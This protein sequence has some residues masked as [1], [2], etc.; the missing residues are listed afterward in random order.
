MRALGNARGNFKSTTL[1]PHLPRRA[2]IEAYGKGGFR[3]AG[4]SHRGS[5]LCLPS[6]VWAWPPAAPTEINAA[7]L[8]P[9]F[10]E[11][12]AIDLFLLGTFG[13]SVNSP[14]V[15]VPDDA[16]PGTHGGHDGGA[17][18]LTTARSTAGG[19]ADFLAQK[20]VI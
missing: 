19:I 4:M 8:A 5:L 6:G 7:A 15:E 18:V 11:A 3:F 17:L 14:P 13:E 1:V 12:D 16:P 9:V 10:A 2:P 20:K